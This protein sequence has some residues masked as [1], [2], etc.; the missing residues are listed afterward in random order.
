MSTNPFVFDVSDVLGGDGT[1]LRAAQLARKAQVPL[2]GINLGQI[3][4]L[5]EAEI[6]DPLQQVRDAAWRPA[7]PVI[8]VV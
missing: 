1:F 4:F 7:Y 3:G 6:A 5:A 8:E 2:L